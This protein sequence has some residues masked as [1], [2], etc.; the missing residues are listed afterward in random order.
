MRLEPKIFFR[1]RSNVFRGLYLV[2]FSIFAQITKIWWVSKVN[3]LGDFWSHR[4]KSIRPKTQLFWSCELGKTVPGDF[5]A[6][7]GVPKFRFYFLLKNITDPSSDFD[8]F[9]R[10]FR[11]NFKTYEYYETEPFKSRFWRFSCVI[12]K[13]TSI[14][15]ERKFHLK[16]FHDTRKISKYTW[17]S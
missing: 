9:F 12:W 15:N 3:I 13:L 8:P 14:M 11:C 7:P 4:W 2:G 6:L 10:I 1:G 16:I 17:K 5:K